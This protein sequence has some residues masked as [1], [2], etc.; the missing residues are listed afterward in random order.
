[1]GGG[2]RQRAIKY[3]QTKMPPR[4]KPNHFVHK[5]DGI[6]GMITQVQNIDEGWTAL[7]VKINRHV[8]SLLK[9]GLH[10]WFDIKF[11]E[12]SVGLATPHEHDWRSRYV[13]HWKCSSHLTNGRTISIHQDPNAQPTILFLCHLRTHIPCHQ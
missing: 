2:E 10:Y 3:E 5:Y 7:K 13:Y 8:A 4:H 9:E 6:K 1:M 11:L 12:V